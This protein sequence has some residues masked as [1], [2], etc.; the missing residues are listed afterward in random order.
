MRR[1]GLAGL[2][3]LAA[4]SILALATAILPVGA[5]LSP[6]WS[7][8]IAPGYPPPGNWQ[9]LTHDTLDFKLAY[10][11]NIFHPAPDRTSEAGFVLVTPDGRAKLLIAAFD[12][13]AELSLSDYRRHVL[14]TSYP[15]ADID[16]A[17]V[18]RSWF[19]V[20][21]T[22]DDMI[23]Y[24]RV[25]FTCSGRRITSWALLYPHAQ[26]HYYNPILEQIARTFRPSRPADAGC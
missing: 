20:S 14:E 23:F 18:R 21:G 2:T 5:P 16:Y 7:A 17:P 4:L 22:R 12:N 6:A 3:L 10:P 9:T 11:G 25:S 19:V 13:D 8:P 26:R 15:G 24:E 1:P